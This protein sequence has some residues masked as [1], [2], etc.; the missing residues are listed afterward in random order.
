MV[1]GRRSQM[2]LETRDY[3]EAVQRALEI[4]QRPELQPAR[5]MDAEIKRFIKYKVDTN[6]YSA[7]SA[8]SKRYTLGEFADF[9]GN[10][11][12]GQVT[13]FHCRHERKKS[14]VAEH[15]N[16][17]KKIAKTAKDRYRCEC[18]I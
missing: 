13:A 12:P 9:V 3:A 6:R 7:A 15:K 16:P 10:V 5:A 4:L 1:E 17:L 18:A 14:G 2:S 8:D 11:S